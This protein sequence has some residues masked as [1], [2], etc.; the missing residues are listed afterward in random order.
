LA[1]G[2]RSLQ[3]L[4]PE[5]REAEQPDNTKRAADMARPDQAE[6]PLNLHPTSG[7]TSKRGPKPPFLAVSLAAAAQ[8]ARIARRRRRVEEQDIQTGEIGRRANQSRSAIPAPCTSP[9]GQLPAR[10]L[11]SRR[12]TP[13]LAYRSQPAARP[14][15]AARRSKNMKNPASRAFPNRGKLGR[16][17]TLSVA[18]RRALFSQKSPSL[19]QTCRQMPQSM[20]G[21]KVDP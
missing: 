13:G 15:A 18:G 2:T 21:A 6:T 7:C 10:W 12:R 16:E 9:Q 20:Q 11:P 8:I 1:H 5:V 17:P 14:S 4:D 19:R 3:L